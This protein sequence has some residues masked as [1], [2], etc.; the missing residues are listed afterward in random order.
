M[1]LYPVFSHQE[2]NKYDFDQPVPLAAQNATFEMAAALS[3]AECFSFLKKDYELEELFAFFFEPRPNVFYVMEAKEV[4]LHKYNQLKGKLPKGNLANVLIKESCIETLENLKFIKKFRQENPTINLAIGPFVNPENVVI[5]A[6]HIDG[7]Y[8]DPEPKIGALQ[9][10]TKPK[11][12][13]QMIQQLKRY[14]KQIIVKNGEYAMF[15]TC[16]ESFA[17]GA[18]IVC[19]DQSDTSA[20]E[21]S[22]GPVTVEDGKMFKNNYFFKGTIRDTIVEWKRDLNKTAFYLNAPS[23]TEIKNPNF[24]ED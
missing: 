14:Q 17:A 8:I 19:L 7:I 23:V 18:D 10:Y 4:E 11:E 22:E 3:D 12:M 13:I 15:D 20:F 6:K 2:K 9:I 21:E 24:K 1:R 16:I 5:F